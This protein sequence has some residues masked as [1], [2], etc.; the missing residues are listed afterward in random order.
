MSFDKYLQCGPYNFGFANRKPDWVEH[1][2][3]QDGL[4]ISYWDT[5]Q[6][7]T[8][9][10]STPA[11]GLILPVDANPRRSSGSTAASWRPR[12]AGYDAPFSLEK[13]DSFTLHLNGTA[14]LHPGSGSPAAV[15]TTA[16]TG[17]RAQPTHSVKVPNNGV[18]ISVTKQQGTSM[19]IHV[20]Q[21]L[22][23]HLRTTTGGAEGRAPLRRRRRSP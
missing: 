8:T 20:W 18:N 4:L 3:Y 23:R 14:E 13:S 22:T 12:V 16:P 21:A 2:P 5:S 10:A 11:P 7:T 15:P 19:D 1:F 17:T 9:P 6:W